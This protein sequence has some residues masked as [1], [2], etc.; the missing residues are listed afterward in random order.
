MTERQIL[1]SNNERQDKQGKL[2]SAITLANDADTRDE[3]SMI[4]DEVLAVNTR[5]Y[6]ISTEHYWVE[7]GRV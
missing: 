7:T 1:R 5:D 2:D 3:G 6:T 4:I